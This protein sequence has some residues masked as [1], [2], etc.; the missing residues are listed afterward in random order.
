[1]VPFRIFLIFSLKAATLLANVESDKYDALLNPLE[2][3]EHI[4][5]HLKISSASPSARYLELPALKTFD[6]AT[7]EDDS[8]AAYR[9]DFPTLRL[10]GRQHVY[11]D[12]ITGR[13][14]WIDPVNRFAQA[15]GRV[16][17]NWTPNPSENLSNQTAIRTL[18]NLKSSN[19]GS[20]LDGNYFRAASYCFYQDKTTGACTDSFDANSELI[21][22]TIAVP[23]NILGV[24]HLVAEPTVYVDAPQGIITSRAKNDGSGYF[25]DPVDGYVAEAEV[26]LFAEVQAY[27][28][29]SEYF[30]HIQNLLSDKDFRLRQAAMGSLNNPES[31]EI[32]V[33]Q[34]L[35]N[36]FSDDSLYIRNPI[37]AGIERGEGSESNPIFI[38]GFVRYSN[39]AYIPAT[40]PGESLG[41]SLDAY[42]AQLYTDKDKFVFFQGI[43]DYAYDPSIVLHELNHGLFHALNPSQ[44][45]YGLDAFGGHAEPGALQEGL[46]DY[47]AASFLNNPKI[48]EYTATEYGASS[49]FHRNLETPKFCPE[50]Y[51][52]Q[53]H[54][55]GTIAGHALW[56]IRQSL[57][58][59]KIIDDAD[60]LDTAVLQAI[61][62]TPQYATFSNFSDA[63]VEAI[64][65][66]IPN[67]KEEVRQILDESGLLNCRR[68]LT[69]SDNPSPK[70]LFIKGPA[71]Y[72]IGNFVG[73]PL[74]IELEVP[75]NTATVQLSWQQH[76]DQTDVL[77]ANALTAPTAE[78]S[79]PI[80]ILASDQPIRWHY[81]GGTATPLVAGKPL[82]VDFEAASAKPAGN[83]Q[84]FEMPLD[85]KIC[86]LKTV[87]LTPISRD[88]NY[89]MEDF[90]VQFVAVD[91]QVPRC[92]DADLDEKKATNPPGKSADLPSSCACSTGSTPAGEWIFILT[93][94]FYRLIRRQT[95]RLQ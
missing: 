52:G 3:L 71:Q 75:N 13:V 2:I 83:R 19:A 86:G 37:E 95:Q 35:V 59:Q 81:S 68:V 7:L 43:L 54:V 79:L 22:K 90:E 84:A 94:C 40:F 48:G 76:H 58:A 67:A 14:L 28:A 36:L 6:F 72:G 73:A 26:D 9:F 63:L 87:Y 23:A 42:F 29:A 10:A 17:K 74:Q 12:A 57:I 31:M 5:D 39:A 11:M 24:N 1:M 56:K 30:E 32:R 51:I 25:Y 80:A 70:T 34:M 77:L 92:P 16:F 20:T 91:A 69:I 82:D 47:L 44:F 21:R 64:E 38:D 61:R 53:V 8:I 85:G 66:S 4:P 93:I 15:E 60:A 78:E 41:S 33:N 49:K 45:M 89:I 50:N 18:R 65:A 62:N 27:Y 46:A 55:D 88:F